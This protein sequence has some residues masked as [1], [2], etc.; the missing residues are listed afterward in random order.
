MKHTTDIELINTK[1]ESIRRARKR[2]YVE[3]A[4]TMQPQG[5]NREDDF[6]T[7]YVLTDFIIIIFFISF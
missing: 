2:F 5:I 1:G 6:S 4:Q 3:R 7:I